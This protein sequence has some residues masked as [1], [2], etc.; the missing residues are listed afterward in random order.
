MTD[1][2]SQRIRDEVQNLQ[3]LATNTDPSSVIFLLD[4]SPLEDRSN[5]SQ[6]NTASASSD[7]IVG[8]ILPNSDIYNKAAFQIEIKL[9]PAYPFMPPEIR[10]ITPIY[11]PNVDKDRKICVNIIGDKNTYKP[12]TSLSEIVQAIV[13]LIDNPQTVD[14][15]NAGKKLFCFKKNFLLF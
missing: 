10:F 1:R 3:S 9:P 15:L 2:R 11:H 4:E 8:K 13:H 6:A 14:P 5:G 12:K 7:I